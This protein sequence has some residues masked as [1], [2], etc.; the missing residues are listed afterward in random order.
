[1]KLNIVLAA[2]L[3]LGCALSANAAT[4][5][6]TT[7]AYAN[8]TTDGA[9][10]DVGVSLTLGQTFTVFTDASQ[11]WYGAAIGDPNYTMLSTNANG[12][13][14]FYYEP[15]LYGIG[16][17]PIGTLVASI[18]GDYRVIGAGTTTLTAWATGEIYFYYADINNYDNSGSVISTLTTPVP[19]PTSLAL[20]I[21][22][23][24]T[25]GAYTRRRKVAAK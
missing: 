25:V 4:Y 3:T 11:I 6:V 16:T 13:T 2:L 7:D 8:S 1:M 23:I 18:N 10:V 19:E 21:A 20:L 14:G 17:T 12:E 22:G 9:G 15:D 5:T 24:G